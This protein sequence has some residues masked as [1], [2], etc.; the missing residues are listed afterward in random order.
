M[1][2]FY[3]GTDIDSARKKANVTIDSLLAK[4]PDATLIK[5][6]EENIS[7]ERIGELASGQALFSEKYIVFF[8]KT[9]RTKKTK[10]LF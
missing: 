2:Y 1:I 8:Y 6:S 10:R 5:I 7:A 3:Y 4:K 9:F